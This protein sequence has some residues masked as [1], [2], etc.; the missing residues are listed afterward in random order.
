MFAQFSNAG[1]YTGILRNTGVPDD[2]AVV[3]VS[4]DTIYNHPVLPGIYKLIQTGIPNTIGVVFGSLS[5]IPDE[6]VKK[7]IL[8]DVQRLKIP[9]KGD[10]K[11]EFIAYSRHTPF[12]LTVSTKAIAGGFYKAL[13]SLQGQSRTWYTGAAFHTQD[14]SLLWQFTEALLPNITAS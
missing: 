7:Q 9:G 6:N 10:T 5:A 2:T 14:S 12:E 4:P 8:S 13:S 3:N 11:P 1:Y